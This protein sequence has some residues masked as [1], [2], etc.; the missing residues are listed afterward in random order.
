[1]DEYPTGVMPTSNDVSGV[2]IPLLISGIFNA[3]SAAGLLIVGLIFLLAIV[4]CFILP[5]G[6]AY[7]VMA[8]FEIKTFVELGNPADHGRLRGRVQA[9]EIIE[10]V[11]GVFGNLPS[12]V[13][14]IIVLVNLKQLGRPRAY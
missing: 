6:I 9:L 2:R 14:G 13:C 3:V 5:F 11:L 12:L 7:G 8:Y 1:M 10:V 4:G